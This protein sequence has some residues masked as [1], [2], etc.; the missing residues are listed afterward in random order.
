MT[1]SVMLDIKGG[2][3]GQGECNNPGNGMGWVSFLGGGGEKFFGEISFEQHL[4]VYPL[5]KCVPKK[6]SY[7]TEASQFR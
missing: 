5:I 4:R 7:Y 6:L 3:K 2:R 1:K